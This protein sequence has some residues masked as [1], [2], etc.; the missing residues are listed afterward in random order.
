MIQI[1]N[2]M[3]SGDKREYSSIKLATNR[4]PVTPRIKL[5]L[6]LARL[7]IRG[8]FGGHGA[9]GPHGG[10]EHSMGILNE[11]LL[12]QA[13]IIFSRNLM[14][15]A[16]I[17]TIC[18]HPSWPCRGAQRGGLL[19]VCRFMCRPLHVVLSSLNPL[20]AQDRYGL[21]SGMPRLWRSP[22]SEM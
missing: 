22:R 17:R 4:P 8:C 11:A 15:G 18:P 14:M 6:Y 12:H 5:H 7:Q 16:L 3:S 21:T 9:E 2:F 20:T 13:C 1:G 19:D 10:H